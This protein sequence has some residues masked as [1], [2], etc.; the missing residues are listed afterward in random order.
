MTLAEQATGQNPRTRRLRTGASEGVESSRSIR[1]LRAGRAASPPARPDAADLVP[2]GQPSP[3][4]QEAS[5]ADQLAEARK[6]IENLEIALRTSRRIGMAMGILMARHGLS[7]EGA[8]AILCEVSQHR[9][10]KLREIADDVVYV[11]DVMPTPR[12]ACE[13]SGGDRSG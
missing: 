4:A 9:H 13:Q 10:R 3:A 11:G 6:R 7:D 12:A 2:S 5:A 8:F 1:S